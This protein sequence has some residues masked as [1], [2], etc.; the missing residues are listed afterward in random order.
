MA[1]ELAVAEPRLVVAMNPSR[2]LDIAATNF[3]YEQLPERR[4][5]GCGVLL[6]SSWMS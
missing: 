6:I 4:R 3:V 5:G 1:R 2:C